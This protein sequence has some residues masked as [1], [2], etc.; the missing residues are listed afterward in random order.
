MTAISVGDSQQRHSSG[1]QTVVEPKSHADQT[2]FS[3]TQRFNPVGFDMR[4]YTQLQCVSG[5]SAT[6]LLR[7]SMLFTTN[8]SVQHRFDSIDDVDLA[9]NHSWLHITTSAQLDSVLGRYQVCKDTAPADTSAVFVVPKP[10]VKRAHAPCFKHMRLLREYPSGTCLLQGAPNTVPI[11][12]WLDVPTCIKSGQLIE[13]DQQL[14]ITGNNSC[15][16]FTATFSNHKGRVKVDTG[17]SH[18]FISTNFVRKAGIAVTPCS[19]AVALADGKQVHTV[20]TCQVRMQLGNFIEVLTFFVLPLSADY[21]VILGANW[22]QQRS[23]VL[24]FGQGTLTLRK[25]ARHLTVSVST[26]QQSDPVEPLPVEQLTLS[27]LQLKKVVRKGAHL[28]L[29]L[30]TKVQDDNPSLTD[31][32]PPVAEGLIPEPQLQAILQSFSDVF[33]DMPGGCIDRPGLTPMR[34]ELE[35]GKAP[36][37]GVSYRLSQPEYLECER[38]IKEALTK[39]L[40][41]PSSSPFGAPVLFVPKKGGALRMC[42]DYRAL[43]KL[44]IKNRYPL[45]RIDDLLD[46]LRG[47]TIFSAIDLQSGYNQLAVH[48]DDCHK[49]AFRTPFGLYQ[50]RVIPFGLTN[51]PAHFHHAMHQMFADM[52]GKFVFVYLDDILVF[53]KT[54]EEHERHLMVVLERLRFYKLYARLPK[55][56]FNFISAS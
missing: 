26:A 52:I 20:G 50:W 17:A 9:N 53:S 34:I 54:P 4:E 27:A 8:D 2:P 5:R 42:C 44:T 13:D 30:V 56:H 47:A 21:D 18:L 15:L 23:V 29:A 24:N 3:S 43:N 39:G 25:G 11:Q 10:L 32:P 45:P 46:R 33:S 12:V 51:A 14:V 49:T 48:A 37:V 6:L 1:N 28:F 19:R 22:L 31:H 55:C 35:P 40:I 41:E 7:D 38:Q 36:P 16:D